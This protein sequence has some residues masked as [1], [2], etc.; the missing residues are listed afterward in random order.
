MTRYLLFT[1]A[2][3]LA[4][5][6]TVAVGERRPTWDRPSKS[7]V[8]GLVAA[9]LG[10]ERS[11][12]I[13]QRRLAL[14]L[15]FAVRIDDAGTIASDY[16]TAE[17]PKDSRVNKD[18]TKRHGPIRTRADEL[19]RPDRKTILSEREFRVGSRYTICLWSTEAGSG[20]ISLE[21]IQTKLRAPKFTPYAGRK[22]HPLMLPMAP[23]LVEAERIEAAFSAFDEAMDPKVKSMLDG[24]QHM[25]SSRTASRPLFAD[26]DAVPAAERA[27]RATQL[28]ERR[29]NPESRDKW[30]FG[31]R[32]ELQLR[33]SPIEGEA[34]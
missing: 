11:D 21:A 31:L 2:A 22:A 15:G 12:E 14:G 5:F 23:C 19:A 33:D 30:R 3:P 17:S 29:D 4:S 32:S 16:H 34:T 9:C 7:Q 28:I 6:G 26:A 18:W 1:H 24:L 25:R 8:T 13:E 20:S 27:A 10:I